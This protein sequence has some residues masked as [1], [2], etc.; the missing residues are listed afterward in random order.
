MT[1]PDAFGPSSLISVWYFFLSKRTLYYKFKKQVDY[2]DFRAIHVSI[3]MRSSSV[4]IDYII[5]LIIANT[6]ITILQVCKV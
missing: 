4:A 2:F 1:L 5:D 3:T 6:A